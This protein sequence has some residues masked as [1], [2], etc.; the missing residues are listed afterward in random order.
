[1]RIMLVSHAYPPTI[2]GVSV[3][4]R[5]LAHAMRRR[6]HEV[7]V[8]AASD[9]GAPYEHHDDGV[10]VVRVRSA[11]NPYWPEGRLPIAGGEH[12]AETV[13]A[14]APDVVHS[15]ESAWLA[16]QL[17]RLREEIPVPT[18]ATCHFVPRFLEHYVR[19]PMRR[20]ARERVAWRVAIRL[21][22]RFDQV[23]FPTAMQRDMYQK[24]GLQAPAKVISNGVDLERYRPDGP[25]EPDG[26][27]L[28][29]APRVLA[30]GRVA[31]DKRL[32]VL[33]HA[34]AYLRDTDTSLVIAGDGAAR[35]YLERLASE[36]ALAERICFVGRIPEAQMPA[37]YRACDA[38]AIPSL[39]EVQSITTLQAL[40]CGVPVVAA[41]AGSLPEAVRHGECGILV[42]PED[43]EA[44]AAALRSIL[45]EP[46]LARRLRSA[47][48]AAV[49]EHDE[50]RT[51]DAYE[52]V[53]FE[54]ASGMTS[55]ED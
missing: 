49:R 30:V 31:R 16:W 41:E 28:P 25:S 17:A 34:F 10:N 38:Y 18:V 22:D 54:V 7:L 53:Y 27:R 50:R 48:L 3:V 21:L 51:F 43:P 40:A 35:P 36:L 52:R 2:S 26:I 12:L 11:P 55:R 1:M 33:V 8:L 37:L 9:R 19:A 47:G 5:K 13:L 44:T 46:A 6:G 15:H 32:D 39:V 4:V 20:D 29:P 24:A 45:S 42:A 23:V 14:F